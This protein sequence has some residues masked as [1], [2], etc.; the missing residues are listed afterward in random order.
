MTN[1]LDTRSKP[2]KYDRMP[3][4]NLTKKSMYHGCAIQ[5]AM[6]SDMDKAC[7]GDWIYG[8][9][10][11]ESADAARGVE[12]ADAA[13]GVYIVGAAHGVCIV[14]AAHG[15]YMVGAARGSSIHNCDAAS[16][17]NPLLLKP[18]ET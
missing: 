9:N 16:M 2:L 17:Q 11:L 14:G 13:H 18:Q 10:N 3:T 8:C 7:A 1:Q 15:V 4:K 6:S 12:I 5:G